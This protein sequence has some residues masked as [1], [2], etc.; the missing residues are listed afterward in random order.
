MGNI[1]IYEVTGTGRR[2]KAIIFLTIICRN[3][4]QFEA[5]LCIFYWAWWNPNLFRHIC[6]KLQPE[7]DHS[8]AP[9]LWTGTVICPHIQKGREINSSYAGFWSTDNGIGEF[10]LGLFGHRNCVEHSWS[11]RVQPDQEDQDVLIPLPEDACPYLM[12]CG[13]AL[14]VSSLPLGFKHSFI[15]M[16]SLQQCWKNRATPQTVR[17]FLPFLLDCRLHIGGF[18]VKHLLVHGEKESPYV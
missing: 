17:A 15:E 11:M 13:H 12:L 8:K 6:P 7:G 14:C 16:A 2:R 4:S 10:L 18:K 1:I 3:T 9:S 5:V